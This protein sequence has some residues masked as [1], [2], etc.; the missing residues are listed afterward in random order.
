MNREFKDLE[1]TLKLHARGLG[2]PDGS[3]NDYINFTIASV[4]KSLQNK[5]IITKADLDRLV[6]KELKK[7]HKDFAYVYEIYDIII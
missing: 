6:I 4:Q 1:K 7:Y 5:S 3:A 2:I